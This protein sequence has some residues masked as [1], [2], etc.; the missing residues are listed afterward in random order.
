MAGADSGLYNTATGYGFG[1]SQAQY[2][3]GALLVFDKGLSSSQI[4]SLNRLMR[5]NFGL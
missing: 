5:T 2:N 3:G 1:S 4:A